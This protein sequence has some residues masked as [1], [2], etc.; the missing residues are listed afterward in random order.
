M[1]ANIERNYRNMPIVQLRSEQQK[2]ET[3]YYFEG[4]ATKFNEPYLL[5]EFEDGQKIY[6]EID[7]NAFDGCDMSDVILQLNHE[8]KVYAR[9]SNKTLFL[10][11]NQSGLLCYGDL[12]KSE[13][14]KQIHEEIK[15]GLLTKMS[16]G[17]V[18]AEEKYN[19]ETH[20]RTILKIKK[21]YDVSVVSIPAN[22]N[23]YIQARSFADGVY[24]QELEECKKKDLELLKFRMK[25]I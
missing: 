19:K 4:Y 16:F 7:R 12:G 24:Q 23:T 11:A 14:S 6:E 5:Y 20:T 15:S 13:A 2:L 8:G 25:G 3:D 18:I 17:F 10:E 22:D 1:P 21:L 9:Q